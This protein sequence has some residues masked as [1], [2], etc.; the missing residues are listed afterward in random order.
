MTTNIGRYGSSAVSELIQAPPTPI[1]INNTG[2]TQHREA[3]TAASTAP[4][5]AQVVPDEEGSQLDL[6]SQ[7]RCQECRQGQL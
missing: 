2:A 4:I 7:V 1:D 6:K 3:P 5:W